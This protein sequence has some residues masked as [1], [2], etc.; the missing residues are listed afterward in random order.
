MSSITKNAEKLNA[1]TS[2]VS[3][4]TVT[5][6]EVSNKKDLRKWVRFP[7]ELPNRLKSS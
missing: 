7:K 5:V 3:V 2:G 6:V 4:K 1:D